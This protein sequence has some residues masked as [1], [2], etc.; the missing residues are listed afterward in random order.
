L[1]LSRSNPLQPAAASAFRGGGSVG[2]PGRSSRPLPPARIALFIVS[3]LLLFLA[4]STWLALY[5]GVPVDLGGAA[6]LDH[7]ARHVRIPV[8]PA[9]SVDG[10][11]LPGTRPVTVLMLHGY[12]RDHHRMWRYAGFL[13]PAGY[14]VLA[15]DFRSSRV[16]NRKPTTLGHY[17]IEDARAA[18]DWLERNPETHGQELLLFGESLGGSVALALAGERPEAAA[19]AADCPFESGARA[20]EDACERWAHLPRWP[21]ALIAAA[22]GAGLTGHDPRS[23]DV[24]AAA[25]TLNGRPMYLIA[26]EHDDRLSTDEARHI[27]SAAAG[28]RDE[29]WV[30]PDC[31]HNEAWRRH[32]PEY[33]QRLLE[34]YAGAEARDSGNAARGTQTLAAAPGNAERETRASAPASGNAERESRAPA[35]TSGT[36]AREPAGRAAKP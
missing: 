11:W 2:G 10:W 5:P 16:L 23:L 33:E 24:L 7:R 25:R 36:A 13:R 34:F 29:L 21:S 9:D 12:G 6:D 18:L 17:E 35:A 1:T 22:L 4:G 20:L 27:S 8:T 30:L 32:R 14:G 3:A 31:G 19:V 15:I 28:G 26:C